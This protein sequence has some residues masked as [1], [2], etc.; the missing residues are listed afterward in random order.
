MHTHTHTHTQDGKISEGAKACATFSYHNPRN[1]H[2]QANIRYYQAQPSVTEEDMKPLDTMAYV[3]T[4]V[5]V[6]ICVVFVFVCV[7]VCVCVCE[8]VCL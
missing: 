7:S 4:G 6:C 8:C 1:I 3:R 5:C 2:I